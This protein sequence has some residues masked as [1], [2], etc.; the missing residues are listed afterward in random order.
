[1]LEY[2]PGRQGTTGKDA[3]RRR[4]VRLLG[5]LAKDVQRKGAVDGTS[6]GTSRASTRSFFP[7]HL[8][9]LAFGSLIMAVVIVLRVIIGFIDR[10]TKGKKFGVVLTLALICFG[11]TLAV[12]IMLATGVGLEA[13]LAALRAAGG[14]SVARVMAEEALQEEYIGYVKNG[15]LAFA[16]FLFLVV[17]SLLYL[18]RQAGKDSREE[19][20]GGRGGARADTRLWDKKAAKGKVAPAKAAKS[21]VVD[22]VK[23]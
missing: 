4:C 14:A 22:T 2:S 6:Y 5:Q 20:R 9:S 23:L 15:V 12:Y 18:C 10:K 11:G 19:R 7:H 3:G 16:L 13:S 1:M 8:G 21:E 17:L